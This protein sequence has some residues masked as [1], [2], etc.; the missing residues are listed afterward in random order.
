M[1]NFDFGDIGGEQSP[2]DEIAQ[3]DLLLDALAAR[4]EGG[5]GD[6]SDSAAFEDQALTALLGDWRDDLRWPPASALVSQEEAEGA[7][8][9]GMLH[10]GGGR[11]GLAAVGSVAATLL[12]LSG[13]GAVVADARPGDLL[14]GLHAMMFNEPRVSDDQIM[15][16]AKADLAKVEQMIAEGQWDQAQNQLAEVSTT[17]RAVNDGGRRQ[18][19]LD[20]VTQLNTKVEKRDPNATARP[21]TPP[22]PELSVPSAPVNSWAPS[23]PLAPA[24]DPTLPAAVEPDPP[25]ELPQP[26]EPALT[27]TTTPPATVTTT[28]PSATPSPSTTPPPTTTT[29]AATT[30]PPT[31]TTSP[32]MTPPTTTPPTTTNPPTTTKP[33]TSTTTPSTAPTTSAPKTTTPPPT[34]PASRGKPAPSTSVMPNSPAAGAG[35]TA[36]STPSGE[37]WDRTSAPAGPRVPRT[38][39]PTGTAP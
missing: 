13:F 21:A 38:P 3:T 36:P 27:P 31:T 17:L 6:I 18:G 9:D 23:Q 24:V 8:R 30:T 11:R 26:I 29:R 19:L 37:L 39:F 32:A 1:R 35:S 22:T 20:E 28:V 12:M 34:P 7:L 33:K 14:Y 16:S 2:L 25:A 4:T 5:L 15:L 10:R